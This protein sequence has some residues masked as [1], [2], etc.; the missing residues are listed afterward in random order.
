[1]L[2][3]YTLPTS[4]S[5]A[6]GVISP[7]AL[8]ISGLTAADKVYDGSASAL[9]STTGA[10][11][12]GIISGDLVNIAGSGIFADKNVGQGK[13]VSITGLV[14]AGP[15][16][17]NYRLTST[18]ASAAA[19]ISRANLLVTGAA[20]NDKMFDGTSSATV[21]GG[22][23]SPLGDDAVSLSAANATFNDASI[24]INK[25]VASFY[26]LIGTDAANYSIVQPN[27]LSASINPNPA[28]LPSVQQLVVMPTVTVSVI[29][30]L[31]PLNTASFSAPVT[32]VGTSST[33]STSVGGNQPSVALTPSPVSS[34]LT[35]SGGSSNQ[36]TASFVAVKTFEVVKVALGTAFTL[37]L[38]DN[39]FTHSVSSTP[40]QISAT[41]ASG[42]PLPDWLRFAP[43]ERRFSGTPPAGVTSL[44]VVVVATDTNGN[45]ASTTVTLQFADA[46]R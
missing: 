9:I 45:Q 11:K 29:P 3:N 20:A 30:P 4:I 36:S 16:A 42:S 5:G 25:P 23:I 44:Q 31:V 35:A 15:D 38:P 21:T 24:G 34:S 6:V 28:S 7:A 37:T 32:L 43:G 26:S 8:V 2:A 41:G 13:A 46:S 39:T 17:G 10:V 33:T 14:L 27:G 22:R 18:S 1:M 12:A 40:L 19:N